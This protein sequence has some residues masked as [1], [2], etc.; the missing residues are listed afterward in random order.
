MYN[1]RGVEISDSRGNVVKQ[2]NIR[3]ERKSRKETDGLVVVSVEVDRSLLQSE[4]LCPLCLK[5][6]G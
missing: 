3:I 5:T 6:R 4:A 2:S 1:N